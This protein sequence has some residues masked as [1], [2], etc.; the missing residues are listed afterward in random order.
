MLGQCLEVYHMKGG[1]V[2]GC[3]LHPGVQR[4][5]QRNLRQAIT[6]SKK[7]KFSPVSPPTDP[8]ACAGQQH[9]CVEPTSPP[10]GSTGLTGAARPGEENNGQGIGTCARSNMFPLPLL[11]PDAQDQAPKCEGLVS[12]LV[13]VGLGGKDPGS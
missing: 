5:H 7:E 8:Q 1:L 12:L 3:A 13:L 11:L 6:G 4:L 9:H 10:V 2:A